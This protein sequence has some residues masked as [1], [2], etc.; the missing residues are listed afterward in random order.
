MKK[1]IAFISETDKVGLKFP[2]TKSV[3]QFSIVGYHGIV[4]F[5]L[6]TGVY[7]EDFKIKTMEPEA[8]IEV[9]IRRRNSDHA[10]LLIEDKEYDRVSN[11]SGI[12]EN[13][14]LMALTYGGQERL[15]EYMSIIYKDTF[16]KTSMDNFL[17]FIC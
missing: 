12:T 6:Y 9:F 11:N 14:L 13:Q 15:F 7:I 3:C 4:M 17:N 10:D 2:V 8:F 16:I 5:S 1:R